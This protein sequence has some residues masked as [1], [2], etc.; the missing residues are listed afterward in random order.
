M[1]HNQLVNVLD[2][3]CMEQD[4]VLSEQI[5]N[6]RDSGKALLLQEVRNLEKDFC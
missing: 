4:T 5:R 3:Q 6:C 2:N 1:V